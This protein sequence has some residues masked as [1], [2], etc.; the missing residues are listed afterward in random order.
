[1][2]A[3][4][5]ISYEDAL[6]ARYALARTRLNRG[7]IH[8]PIVLPPPALEAPAEKPKPAPKLTRRVRFKQRVPLDMLRPCSWRFLLR[9]AALRHRIPEQAIV[10][11]S[12]QQSIAAARHDA[13]G[14]VYQHTQLS[15]PAVGR[16]FGRDHTTVLNSL[17]KLG[18]EG[19][20]VDKRPQEKAAPAPKAKAAAPKPKPVTQKERKRT[21][22]QNA[23]ARA[24]NHNV[25]P[26]VLADEYGCNPE[27]VKVIAH[28][29]GL[30]RSD[31]N[32]KHKTAWAASGR[33][34]AG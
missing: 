2:N 19:K 13:I 20:L 8:R 30:R 3:I 29:L 28:R 22:L 5:T 31:F 6:K 11:Q 14:M 23:V 4:A 33:E 34:V 17:R 27:S 16:F 15:M 1:M 24:Y 18:R 32:G 7:V 12:R 21:A 9:L 25:M 26:S 10:G